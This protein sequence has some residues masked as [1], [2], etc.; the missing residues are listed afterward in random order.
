MRRKAITVRNLPREVER[1]V[2]EKARNEGLSLNRAVAALLEEATGRRATGRAPG[3]HDF[4]KYAGRWGKAKADAF[5]ASLREQRKVDPAD[6][7]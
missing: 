1:A 7:R 5:D 3:H 4:D 6:W 2:Q